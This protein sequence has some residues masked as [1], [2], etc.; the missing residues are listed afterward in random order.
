MTGSGEGGPL[1]DVLIPTYRRPGGL[2]IT[3]TGLVAQTYRSFRVVVSDQT[4]DEPAIDTPEVEAIARIL[5]ATG[6]PVERLRHLPR[7]GMAEHRQWLLGRATAP[8][9]LFLDDDVYLAPDL[10]GR[11]VRHLRRE[12]CGFVGSGLIGLSHVGDE[13]PHEE[14]IQFWDGPV[15]PERVRP[16][17]R[18]WARHRLHS[19]AN[20]AHL[21]RRIRPS[22]DRLYRV[23]WVGGCVLYDVAKL[24]A[25]GGF[26]FW[27]RLPDRHA[28]EDV[29]AQLA[30][31]ERYGGAAV[32]PSGAYHLELPT[33]IPQAHRAVD[34]PHALDPDAL[35]RSRHPRRKNIPRLAPPG[36]AAARRRAPAPARSP[37]HPAALVG[38]GH[39]E[40]DR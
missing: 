25:S 22:D 38:A 21:R 35:V 33:T 6:R 9:A 29:L 3:L 19:A 13:R 8:Y 14:E 23:A 10:I 15:R 26:G 20:L 28:G 31:M 12:G 5:A 34:A 32:F 1:V 7:R 4:D 40:G 24:R 37:R 36:R 11:L 2:A 17:T 16:G 30:V 39:G 18:E 27:R